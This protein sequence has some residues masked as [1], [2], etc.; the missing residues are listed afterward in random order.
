MAD[1]SRIIDVAVKNGWSVPLTE[2]NIE[3]GIDIQLDMNGYTILPIDEY[4]NSKDLEE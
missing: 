2:D 3:D 4:I 1:N